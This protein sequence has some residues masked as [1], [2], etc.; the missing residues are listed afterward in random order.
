MTGPRQDYELWHRSVADREAGLPAGSAPPWHELVRAHLAEPQDAQVLEMACGRGQFAVELERMGLRVF[1]A[2]FS[3]AA[4]RQACGLGA[5]RALASDAQHLPFPDATFE[6]VVSCET[7]EHLPDWRAGLAELAR[8]LRPGGRLY[9]TFPSYLNTYG[10]YRAYLRL[11]G[12]PFNSGDAVQPVEQLLF[13]GA[14]RRQLRA[15]GLDVLAWDALGH[16]FLLPRVNPVRTRQL[17]I[18]RR[19]FLRRL[20]R[21]LALHQ[22]I[23]AGKRLPAG[24]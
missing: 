3:M 8:V 6:A 4:L 17:W 13:C 2:D 19:P 9:L 14:V 1:A 11:R 12:R 7:I 22:M 5:S 15:L 20:L 24:D 23:V 10:L 21:A 18:E 16:Y